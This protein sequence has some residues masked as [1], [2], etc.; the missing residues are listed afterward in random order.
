MGEDSTSSANAGGDNEKRKIP[1]STSLSP[2][3]GPLA[4]LDGPPRDAMKF[5]SSTPDNSYGERDTRQSPKYGHIRDGIIS[6]QFAGHTMLMDVFL[7][8]KG[9]VRDGG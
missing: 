2:T 1:L 7:K 4:V 3:I 9:A 5:P 6:F 8:Q